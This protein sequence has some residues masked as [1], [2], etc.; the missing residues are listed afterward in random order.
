MILSEK[1]TYIRQFYN[2]ETCESVEQL[3]VLNEQATKNDL[4]HFFSLFGRVL[5]CDMK[6]NTW[7]SKRFVCLL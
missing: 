6:H 5:D 3:F 1:Y 4:M 2:W 7:N